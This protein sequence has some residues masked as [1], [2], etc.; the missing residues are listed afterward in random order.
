MPQPNETKNQTAS[1]WAINVS[2]AFQY[3]SPLVSMNNLLQV[4]K[5][6]YNLS[7]PNLSSLTT[8]LT[9][10]EDTG[11]N[12]AAFWSPKGPKMAIQRQSFNHP[13]TAFDIRD[14]R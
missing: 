7:N 6:N 5:K 1:T 3:A 9:R 12:S 13:V 2:V 10:P 11:N 14:F 4:S 8:S